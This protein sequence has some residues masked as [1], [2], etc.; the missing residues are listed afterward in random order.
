L[1]YYNKFAKNIKNLSEDNLTKLLIIVARYNLIENYENF[2]PYVLFNLKTT[3]DNLNYFLTSGGADLKW[4]LA[5]YNLKLKEFSPFFHLAINDLPNYIAT[6][7]NTSTPISTIKTI[8]QTLCVVE[9]LMK[10]NITS[11]DFTQTFTKD[12]IS[13]LMTIYLSS[14]GKDYK[15]EY[16]SNILFSRFKNYNHLKQ[17]A[18][19]LDIFYT[20]EYQESSVPLILI[21]NNDLNSNDKL[22]GEYYIKYYH[23]KSFAQE[24]PMI[25]NVDKIKTMDDL[26]KAFYEYLKAR[27][28]VYKK[29]LQ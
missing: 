18:T 14:S 17:H 3:N 2:P 10:Y 4:S 21:D 12:L 6:F 13:S 11:E 29:Y 23:V 22:H 15:F 5:F 7:V 19:N 9:L 20:L 16:L 27:K 1:G 24:P 8:L 25:I 28:T 26:E